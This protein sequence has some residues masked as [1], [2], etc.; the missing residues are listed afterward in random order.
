MSRAFRTTRRSTPLGSPTK[1]VPSVSY[2]SQMSRATRPWAGRQG[3]MAKL[4]RSGNRYWSDSFT[5][6]NPSMEEPSNMI[7]L[8]NALP[9]CEA[10]MATF[11]SCP[12]MSTNCMRMNSISSS[13]TIRRMSSLV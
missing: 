9:V 7:W 6:V 3:K 8:F 1:G 5:R 4:L 13:S 10:V 11:F 12:K 2:T